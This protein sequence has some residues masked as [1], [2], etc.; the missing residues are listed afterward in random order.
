MPS[1]LIGQTLIY[2]TPRADVTEGGI[3]GSVDIRTLRPLDLK[4]PLT[5]EASVGA[6]YT[7]A[8]KK[9]DP[10]GSAL[11]GWNNADRTIGVLLQAYREDRHL[12]RDGQ[13]VFSYAT[14]AATSA[15]ATA[16]PELANKRIPN[17]LNSALFTGVRE[18]EGGYLGIQFK[19]SS[20]VDLNLSAFYSTL[21][22]DNYN[23]SAF[24]FLGNMI[25]QGSLL[26]NVAIDGDVVTRGNL[27]TPAGKT[28]Q[29]SL[30]FDHIA[31][32]G[33]NSLSSFYDLDGTF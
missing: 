31:R 5:V 8:P 15:A 25:A 3:S 16:N 12:R 11:F 19:P 33:A 26:T 18:R 32:E 20:A 14:I 13:E 23:S 7:G 24:A 6:V 17:V 1:Q 2:K 29:L 27:S 21:K 22:A 9:T 30:E 28:D 4:K 10:Q